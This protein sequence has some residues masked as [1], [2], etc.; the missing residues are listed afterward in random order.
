MSRARVILVT[1]ANKGIG[2]GI[3]RTLLSSA[4]RSSVIY[5]TSRNEA[6]RKA[7]SELSG[8]ARNRNSSTMGPNNAGVVY[9]YVS[10]AP[11]PELAEEMVK[12][13]YYRTLNV[14][15]VLLGV[16]EEEEEEGRG[17]MLRSGTTD[18][19]EIP[20]HRALRN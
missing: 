16:E 15:S 3:V 14:S 13:N 4:P 10:P 17:V 12:I 6:G 19:Q 9:G 2:Y 20:P 11:K 1:G 8:G 7:L 5:L 18:V